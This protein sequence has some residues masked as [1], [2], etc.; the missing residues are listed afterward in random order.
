MCGSEALWEETIPSRR[1]HRGKGTTGSEQEL[2]EHRGGR[3]VRDTI[4]VCVWA[5]GRFSKAL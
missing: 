2:W 1:N 3:R 4:G 5:G